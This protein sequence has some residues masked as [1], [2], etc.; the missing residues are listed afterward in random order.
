[1]CFLFIFHKTGP[2]NFAFQLGQAEM[3][4][5]ARF[6]IVPRLSLF[7]YTTYKF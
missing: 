7:I 4:L 1:M 6:P 2:L 5:T 3:L